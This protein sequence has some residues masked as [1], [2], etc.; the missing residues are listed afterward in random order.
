M[1]ESFAH[2]GQG[3]DSLVRPA[4]RLQGIFIPGIDSPTIQDGFGLIT[5]LGGGLS[6]R[7]YT[8]YGV[9]NIISPQETQIHDLAITPAEGNIFNFEG[10]IGPRGIPGPPGAPGLIQIITASNFSFLTAPNSSFL[11]ALPPNI[12]QI[13]QL[14]TAVD[15]MVYVSS[16][17][18]TR[19]FVW[20]KTD[21]DSVVK[22]WN[23]SDINTDASFFIIAADA[24]IYVSTDDGDSWDKYNPDGDTY[25]QANCQASG[26]KAVVL[27]N[28][29]RINGTI[30]TTT[31]YG[32]N[33]VEKT[34]VG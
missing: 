14:G 19:N 9:S 28:T 24:G 18:A 5:P 34:V 25:I 8:Q 2:S 7:Q 10:L 4:P 23:D 32:A 13:N 15:T 3:D 31:D 33:W 29:E 22:S 6:S 16:Y 26:G 20:T 12:D 30:W 21:I 17:D 1:S 27:G 11:T